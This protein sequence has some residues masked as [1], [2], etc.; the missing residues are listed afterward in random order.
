MSE[1]STTV[2]A[3]ALDAKRAQE[4][5]YRKKDCLSH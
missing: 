3:N 5:A 4:K 2:Y 1:S